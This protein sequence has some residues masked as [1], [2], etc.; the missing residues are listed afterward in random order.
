MKTKLFSKSKIRLP[1]PYLLE[2]Q[3]SS[4]EEFWQRDLKEL[5]E[6][7]SPIKDYTGKE[8]ELW[9][10]DYK[11]GEPKYK[12][13]FE[14]KANEDSYSAPL[15]AIIKLVNFKTKETKTQEVFLADFPLM[16]ERGTFVI[17]GVE[18]VVIS[19]LL[20]SPGAF[21]T[22]RQIQGRKYFG[23]RIIPN[24]GA[25]LEFETDPSGFIGVKIDRRKRVPATTLLR[26]F[27]VDSDK[28]IKEQFFDVDVGEIKYIEETLKRD[29]TRNQ[30]D[31]LV[32]IYR[33]LRPGDLASADTAK[34]LIEN[35]FFNFE[36][37][38]LSKMGR[39]RMY[40]VVWVT[41]RG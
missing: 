16:T 14:A 6:E 11:L 28:K 30:G 34:E 37:Y 2:I 36:R 18:R 32:E 22:A 24:R 9:F 13:E 7:I 8:F 10:L 40:G 15:R 38:D 27:G 17:N 35:M 23:A 20:R 29:S 31:A 12:D 19:Q 26:A 1:L 5:F 21:F 39:W 41:S 25:W 4:W 3:K 33:R